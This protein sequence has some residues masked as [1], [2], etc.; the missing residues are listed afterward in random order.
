MNREEEAC[1]RET[2][3]LNIVLN[4]LQ[5]HITL[6]SIMLERLLRILVLGIQQQ[7]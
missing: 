1:S 4:L 5:K 7:P 3:S 6:S 2:V